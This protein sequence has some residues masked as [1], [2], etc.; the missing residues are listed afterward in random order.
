[1]RGIALRPV[2]ISAGSRRALWLKT[3]V[4]PLDQELKQA[5]TEQAV[6]EAQ[7]A[8][9]EGVAA[10][11]RGDA[12]ASP[13]RTGGG[14]PGHRRCGGADRR[15]Q[16]AIATGF[17]ASRRLPS[18]ACGRTAAGVIPARRPGDDGAAPAVAGARRQRRYRRTGPRALAAQLDAA[19]D[20]RS[21]GKPFRPARRRAAIARE[22]VH[23]ARR[24]CPKP[25]RPRPQRQQYALLEEKAVQQALA[26]GGQALGASDVAIA[27]G[28]DVERLHIQQSNGQSIRAVA[29]QLAADPIPRRPARSARGERLD[30]LSLISCPP[31]PPSPKVSS[32]STKAAY[33]RAA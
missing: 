3:A 27:A 9:L 33:V 1:M 26:S 6:A 10:R 5:E 20:P 4:E 2:A 15:G 29:N 21:H 13:C 11:A 28:E 14:R 25:R 8:R 32:P 24:A 22:R 31:R 18:A 16:R 30:R 7:A 12:D 19:R 23:G 17:G